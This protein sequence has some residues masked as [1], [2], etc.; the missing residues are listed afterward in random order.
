VA[1]FI[2]WCFCSLV[3]FGLLYIYGTFTLA[4][5]LQDCLVATARAK[6]SHSSLE[7]AQQ[8]V[9][10]V[11][12]RAGAEKVLFDRFRDAVGSLGHSPPCQYVGSWMSSRKDGTTYQVDLNEDGSFLAQ[13]YDSPRRGAGITGV[14]GVTGK[15]MVW[16]YDTGMTWPPDVNP[17]KEESSKGFTLVEVNGSTSRYTPI[18][19]STRA[20]SACRAT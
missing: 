5:H 16:L 6:A 8:V 1:R 14:W 19:G 10:C 2:L 11:D 9:A 4:M 20:G 17:I 7:S 15:R 12:R 3:A 18:E 13:P